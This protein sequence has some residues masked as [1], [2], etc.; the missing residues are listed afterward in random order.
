MTENDSGC[1]LFCAWNSPGPRPPR[2][3]LATPR[4]DPPLEADR[5]CLRVP[6]ED[7]YTAW[8]SA[9]GCSRGQ[10]PPGNEECRTGQREGLKR[11]DG[12]RKGRLR[13]S[14]HFG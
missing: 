7:V 9:Q 12:H 5:A 10:T 6:P 13:P 1:T 14:R 3:A 2:W 4:C 11:L 8:V